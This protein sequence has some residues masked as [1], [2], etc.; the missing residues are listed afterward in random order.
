MKTSEVAVTLLVVMTMYG[1]EESSNVNKNGAGEASKPKI[2]LTE[3]T[4]SE[5]NSI[6]A[7]VSSIVENDSQSL[8]DVSQVE[9]ILKN[10]AEAVQGHNV[11]NVI[12]DTEHVSYC[13]DNSSHSWGHPGESIHELNTATKIYL[14]Q[15]GKMFENIESDSVYILNKKINIAGESCD[16]V[17]I[18]NP[19]NSN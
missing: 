6:M 18:V 3:E 12:V 4:I 17:V 16:L 10:A 14:G 2:T 19:N 8:S 15:Y 13:A 9:P 5:L 11:L 1:C 7:S